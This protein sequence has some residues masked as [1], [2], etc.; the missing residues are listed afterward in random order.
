MLGQAHKHNLTCQSVRGYA[1]FTH[2][3]KKDTFMVV[4]EKHLICSNR[5]KRISALLF[6]DFFFFFRLQEWHFLC[7]YWIFLF[8]QLSPLHPLQ[9]ACCFGEGGMLRTDRIWIFQCSLAGLSV[10]IGTLM[11]FFPS[12]K[13]NTEAMIIHFFRN[14]PAVGFSQ[15]KGLRWVKGQFTQPAYVLLDWNSLT[16][17]VFMYRL[18]RYKKKKNT[19]KKRKNDAC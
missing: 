7:S 3:Q 18:D 17:A 8:S 15:G 12:V 11:S 16:T 6:R 5:T 2:T 13:S 10:G 14:N 1:I 4:H 19:R 9:M